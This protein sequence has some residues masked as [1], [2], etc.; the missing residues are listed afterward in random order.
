MSEL[1]CRERKRVA[2]EGNTSAPG[3]IYGRF[4]NDF[5]LF[6]KRLY[7]KCF[8]MRRRER[9]VSELKEIEQENGKAPN[10]GDKRR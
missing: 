10:S 6:F 4:V 1:G 2:E 8:L 3:G 7:V 9:T 5:L